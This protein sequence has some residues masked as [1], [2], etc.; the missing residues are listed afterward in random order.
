MKSFAEIA[1]DCF[2]NLIFIKSN[3][4]IFKESRI[5]PFMHAHALE[6]SLKSACL[7]LDVD[8]GLVILC[9]HKI[10]DLYQLLNKNVRIESVFPSK[11][12]FD[13]IED[14]FTKTGVVKLPEGGAD[15]LDMIEFAFFIKNNAD[16]K[17][18]YHRDNTQVS[19]IRVSTDHINKFW[20]NFFREVRKVYSDKD[21]NDRFLKL[22]SA[23]FL[24]KNNFNESEVRKHGEKLLNL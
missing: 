5:I 10:I 4:V 6:L 2:L 13:K 3:P 7:R 11:N 23:Y 24:A 20:L 9:G 16:L 15:E 8:E 18:G 21:L 14:V 19:N 12:N 22:L 17:Y 1:D